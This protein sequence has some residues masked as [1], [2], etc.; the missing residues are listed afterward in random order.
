MWSGVMLIS[1]S[2]CP[3]RPA[4]SF[5][6]RFGSMQSRL[7]Q[8]SSFSYSRLH[9]WNKDPISLRWM[10]LPN[11]RTLVSL[12]V[13]RAVTLSQ[14]PSQKSCESGNSLP[15]TQTRRQEISR[16]GSPRF[17]NSRRS[18]PYSYLLRPR[19]KEPDTKSPSKRSQKPVLPMTI[20]STLVSGSFIALP[21]HL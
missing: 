10:R 3:H 15:C 12:V 11:A 13:H 1:I 17:S 19:S 20:G 14:L 8:P 4:V 16:L 6:V 18:T 5:T 7:A 21:R 2:T 9:S